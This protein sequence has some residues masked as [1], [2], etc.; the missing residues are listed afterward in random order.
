MPEW[1][2]LSIAAISADIRGHVELNL[3]Q[4]PDYLSANLAMGRLTL[5]RVRTRMS[6]VCATTGKQILTMTVISQLVWQSQGTC[7]LYEFS[8][9]SSGSESWISATNR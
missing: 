4:S 2:F 1:H 3:L 8:W 7:F 5:Q 6:H 9:R